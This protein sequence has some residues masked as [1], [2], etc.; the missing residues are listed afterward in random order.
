MNI[1]A[2]DFQ[3]NVL[4]SIVRDYKE[5]V[6]GCNLDGAE[7]IIHGNSEDAF[8][9]TMRGRIQIIREG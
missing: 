9:Y 1:S 8:G 7:I 2:C 3:F 5:N 6:F 4:N